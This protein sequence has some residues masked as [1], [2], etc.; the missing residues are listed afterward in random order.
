VEQFITMAGIPHE[1]LSS[2]VNAEEREALVCLMKSLRFDILRPFSMAT[3]MVTGGGVSLKEVDP[4][5]MVSKL[6]DG[7]FLCGEL[8]DLDAGTG[9]FN[10][11]AAFSTGYI[12]GE[13]AAAKER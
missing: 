6:V 8:L 4:R 1:K 5:T 12:A 11:Q 10:L 3:A 7:L 13:S 9:G 2:Q